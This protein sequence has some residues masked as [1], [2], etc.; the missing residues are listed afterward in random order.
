MGDGTQTPELICLGSPDGS[1]T[2]QLLQ[3]VGELL[4]PSMPEFPHLQSKTTSS[5]FFMCSYGKYMV[6]RGKVLRAGSRIIT[7]IEVSATKRRERGFPWQ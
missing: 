3:W 7:D 6:Y 2:Q 4:N 5:S 1:A